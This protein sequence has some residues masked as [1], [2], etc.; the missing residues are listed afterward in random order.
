MAERNGECQVCLWTCA[1]SEWRRSVQ[2]TY[3]EEV[4]VHEV[5][6]LSR[7]TVRRFT[8]W[9]WLHA[10]MICVHLSEIWRLLNWELD[11]IIWVWL[12]C[13]ESLLGNLDAWN[14]WKCVRHLLLF[15][16]QICQ[17][18]IVFNLVTKIISLS[19][20]VVPQLFLFDW[21]R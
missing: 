9:S 8:E 16:E 2:K 21:N 13:K 20:I 6:M 17:D 19:E 1:D 5:L 11:P 18:V 3:A 14:Q 4:K 7:L 12:M 10:L 15:C